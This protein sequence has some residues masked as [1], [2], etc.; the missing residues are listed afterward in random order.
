MKAPAL[1]V[2]PSCLQ[3]GQRENDYL[4]VLVDGW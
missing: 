2:D 4:G 3:L 1:R